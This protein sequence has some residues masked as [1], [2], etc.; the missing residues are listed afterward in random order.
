MLFLKFS[1]TNDPTQKTESNFIYKR[2]YFSFDGI[3]DFLTGTNA[4]PTTK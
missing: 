1:D 4:S 2:A 3:T